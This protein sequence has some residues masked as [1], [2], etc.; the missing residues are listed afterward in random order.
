[1]Y[2]SRSFWLLIF[3]ILLQ[4]TPVWSIGRVVFDHYRPA[5]WLLNDS[6]VLGMSQLDTMLQSEGLRP[7][8]SLRPLNVIIPAMDNQDVLLLSVSK[9][10]SYRAEEIEAVR[11]FVARGGKLLAFGEHDDV[12]KV[13][14]QLQNP[15]LA[16]FGISFAKDTIFSGGEQWISV[17]CSELSV[18]RARLYATVTVCCRPPARLLQASIPVLGCYEND[19]GGRVLAVGDSEFPLNGTPGFGIDDGDNRIFSLNL[20]RFLLSGRIP[21]RDEPWRETMMIPAM[22][23]TKQRVF[24]YAGPG[25][26]HNDDEADGF[27]ILLK[28]LAR[29]G[30]LIQPMTDLSGMADGA[31]LILLRPLQK[32]PQTIRWRRVV[33]LADTWSRLD[34]Y[35]DNGILLKEIGIEEHNSPPG[36]VQFLAERGVTCLPGN[37]YRLEHFLEEERSFRI[38]MTD[39]VMLQCKRASPVR[40]DS[41][42]TLLQMPEN[43][44]ATPVCLGLDERV[45]YRPQMETGFYDPRDDRP[46]NVGPLRWQKLSGRNTRPAS[47]VPAG[48][49]SLLLKKGEI[50]VLADADAVSNQLLQA[51]PGNLELVKRIADFFLVP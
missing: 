41:A 28:T 4:V 6:G 50:L 40:A 5:P 25:G 19:Q 34:E 38:E 24:V 32:I 39:G 16:A 45:P 30:L 44:Y 8:V 46:E 43:T 14:S 36:F 3:W 51:E 42:E 35:T 1:M 29:N 20:I 18:Q 33:V 31:D 13:S 23:S 7:I 10:C 17:A 49:W 48:P 27:S 12:Y 37:V 21:E 11:V 47:D 26:G 9:F 2:C 15:M 22:G